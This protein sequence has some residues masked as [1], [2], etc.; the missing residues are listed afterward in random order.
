MIDLEYQQQSQTGLVFLS[1]G[2]ALNKFARAL[3][4]SHLYATHL[5]AV[6]DN[7]GSTAQLRRYCDIAIGD[8]RNR[9]VA[10]ADHDD[11]TARRVGELFATRLHG[12]KPKV[13][14][15]TT[16]QE[17]AEGSSE[18]LMG[19]PQELTQQISETL[20]SLLAHLPITFD[21]RDGS[22]GN[23]ILVGHYLQTKDWTATL[24]WAH[25][26]LAARGVVLPMTLQSAHLGATLM[27]GVNVVGQS[28]LTDEQ[29]PIRSPI[30]RLLL[31]PTDKS[32]AKTARVKI[33]RAAADAL[34]KARVIVYSWG[35]FYTSVLSGFLVDGV[36][37][38]VLNSKA[39]KVLMINPFPDAETL[40]KLPF[41]LVKE[42]ISYSR[43]DKSDPVG[44]AITHAIALTSKDSATHYYDS[45]GR[46]AIEQLG[47]EVIE[48]ECDGS[49]TQ[50]HLD[51]IKR[52]L[53]RLRSWKD[54]D[55]G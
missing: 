22:I 32:F 8:I 17:I 47:V 26:I 33:Y 15:R 3:A 10:L 25:R 39:A 27:N 19:L 21:W 46:A 48:I 42:I 51:M 1:G 50:Q 23:F 30:Q 34:Q 45:S 55:G 20:V 7:G 12:N 41:D 11:P 5:I 53:L 52:E 4:H 13:M 9:I 14:M 29:K 43:R 36:G 54:S 16:I 49:P 31:H 2:S 44:K 6:F 37:S 40:G 18:H 28:K 24:E 35:S 38:A